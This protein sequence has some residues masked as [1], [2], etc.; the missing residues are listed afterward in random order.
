M[1][2][3]ATSESVPTMEFLPRNYVISNLKERKKKFTRSLERDETD[4]L[5]PGKKI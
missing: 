3:F 2:G 4:N 1:F 5:R